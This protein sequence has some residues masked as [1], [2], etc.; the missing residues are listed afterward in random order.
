[1]LEPLR[2]NKSFR[3]AHSNYL[4]SS[5]AC[6][7]CH[8]SLISLFRAV[9][10]VALPYFSTHAVT[11]YMDTMH[12][13]RSAAYRIWQIYS[14]VGRCAGNLIVQDTN[15]TYQHHG[16]TPYRLRDEHVSK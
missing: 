4:T 1:M 15:I 14:C 3:G 5:D 10:E 16:N 13:R 7:N 9:F 2:T 6:W 8:G 11:N 12:K